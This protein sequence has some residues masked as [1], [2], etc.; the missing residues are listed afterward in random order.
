MPNWVFNHLTID[1]SKEDIAKVK[2]QVGAVVKRK[3]KG[4]DEVDE[5]I[6]EEPQNNSNVKIIKLG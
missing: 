2:A 1:G 5:K 6:D 3:Y 4:V